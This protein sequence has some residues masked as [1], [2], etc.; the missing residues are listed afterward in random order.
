M[1]SPDGNVGCAEI[2]PGCGWANTVPSPG[3]K[4]KYRQI[5]GSRF[6]P[7]YWALDT[8]ISIVKALF[9]IGMIFATVVHGLAIPFICLNHPHPVL[10]VVAII[11]SYVFSVLVLVAFLAGAHLCECVKDTAINTRKIADKG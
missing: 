3:L 2:C 5:K 7:R 4:Q 8:I 9:V 11:L 10:A 1:E 6:A